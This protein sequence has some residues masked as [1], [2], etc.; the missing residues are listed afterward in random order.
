MFIYDWELG[1]SSMKTL[2]KFT[3]VPYSN[4]VGLSNLTLGKPSF[5]LGSI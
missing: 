1:F 4:I 2:R 5:K 3:K